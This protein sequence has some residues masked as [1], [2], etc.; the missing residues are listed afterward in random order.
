MR[1]FVV[2]IQ[3][4][5]TKKPRKYLNLRGFSYLGA[6]GNKLSEPLVL[7]TTYLIQWYEPRVDLAELA[8]LRY[9]EG[10]SRQRLASH[11]GRTLNAI[12]NYCQTIRRRDFR[13]PGLTEAERKK[14]RWSY[15]N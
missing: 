5:Q 11:Y 1:V 3:Y 12:T 15:K 9:L 8:K 13:I 2:Q 6:R 4:T 14:I 7:D 10:W